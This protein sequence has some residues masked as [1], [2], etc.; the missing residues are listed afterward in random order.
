MTGCEYKDKCRSY[1]LK[2]FGCKHNPNK[3]DYFEPK[4]YDPTKPHT[5]H[6]YFMGD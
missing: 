6:Y 1:P 4:P 5:I 2:C 3:D